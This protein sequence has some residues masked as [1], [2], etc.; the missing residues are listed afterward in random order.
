MRE[1]NEAA[2]PMEHL[3]RQDFLLK[4]FR[5]ERDFYMDLIAF[6]FLLLIFR[7]RQLVSTIARL[8]LAN[9]LVKKTE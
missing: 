1:L 4:K 6:I 3:A 2:K 7:V 5:A 9:E 8:K